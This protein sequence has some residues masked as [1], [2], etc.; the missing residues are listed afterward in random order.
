VGLG[1]ISNQAMGLALGKKGRSRGGA[2]NLSN[3]L[4]PSINILKTEKEKSRV[5]CRCF[6]AINTDATMVG[7]LFVVF[8][9]TLSSEELLRCIGQKRYIVFERATLGFA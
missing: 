4:L 5:R 8:R 9:S 7:S 2:E 1:S 3:T 6:L